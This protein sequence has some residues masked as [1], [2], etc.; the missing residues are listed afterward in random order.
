MKNQ[1]VNIF[2]NYKPPHMKTI[3]ISLFI[4][5]IL[6]LLLAETT[7]SLKP[8][9]VTLDRPLLAIGIMIAILGL[10]LIHHSGKVEG[11]KEI[12]K[13]VM[14]MRENTGEERV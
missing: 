11:R 10:S 4:L 6:F 3:I 12:I 13:K 7:I 14:E 1:R 9:K 8:F 2:N 5:V